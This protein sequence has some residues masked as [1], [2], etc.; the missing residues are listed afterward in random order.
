MLKAENDGG[1]NLPVAPRRP[2]RSDTWSF[3]HRLGIGIL[4]GI[5]VIT[6]ST[7]NSSKTAFLISSPFYRAVRG[8]RGAQGEGEGERD[9]NAEICGPS[10]REERVS[11][12][13]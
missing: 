7:V 4:G 13:P 8:T 11:S 6:F 10:W 1:E 3:E 2:R 12:R 5:F 9:T